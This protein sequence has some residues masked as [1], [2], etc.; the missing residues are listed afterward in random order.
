MADKEMHEPKGNSTSAFTLIE[1]LV[2]ISI[3]GILS[4]VVLAALNAARGN[5]RDARRLSDIN[6]LRTAF[7][8]YANDH[9]GTL[10]PV[11]GAH[12]L[13]L[14]DGATCWNGYTY[15]GGPGYGGSTALMQALAP[16]ISSIPLDPDAKR[17]VGDTYIYSTVIESWHCTNPNPPMTGPF[18]AWE[19][20][21]TQPTSDKLC[22]SG[23][24]TCCGPLA[25]GSNYFCVLKVND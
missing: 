13:G 14:P 12:C 11:G 19:P 5:A 10:P 22:G 1:L 3:I 25:C 16:Y 8:L 18:I 23:S 21:N 17:P 2:V 4:A 7:T 20:E 9:N 6:Q 15:V 24:W